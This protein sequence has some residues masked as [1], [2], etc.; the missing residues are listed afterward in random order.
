MYS[1]KALLHTNGSLKLIFPALAANNYYIAVKHR[2][3]ME[4]WSKV[5]VL[6]NKQKVSFDFTRQ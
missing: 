2:S 5:A 1:S 4:T 6:F 3:G